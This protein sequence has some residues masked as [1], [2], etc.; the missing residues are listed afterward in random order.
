MFYI[1]SGANRVD[2]KKLFGYKPKDEI[3]KIQSVL[4][5]HK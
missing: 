5:V 1:R 3:R 4:A 2:I